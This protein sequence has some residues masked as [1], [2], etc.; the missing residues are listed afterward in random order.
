M[1]LAELMPQLKELTYKEK[2]EAIEFLK[3]DLGLQE[4]TE[5]LPTYQA[6]MDL[7]NLK[8][9]EHKLFSGEIP[10]MVYTPFGMEEIAVQVMEMLQKNE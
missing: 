5:P 7:N 4:K 9:E 3:K 6:L 1:T 8:E 2:F 10:A